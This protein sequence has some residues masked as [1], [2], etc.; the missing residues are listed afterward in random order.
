MK[1]AVLTSRNRVEIYCPVGFGAT[2][3]KFREMAERD[4]QNASLLVRIWIERYVAIKDPSNPQRPLEQFDPTFVEYHEA[5]KDC[6]SA[7]LMNKAQN[8]NNVIK[9]SQI[10]YEY[11]DLPIIKTRI[12]RAEEMVQVLKKKGLIIM[13]KQ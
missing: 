5:Q 6:V 3:K 8:Q 12:K 2:W 4:G 11:R 1:V 13:R 10:I 9:W 7:Y